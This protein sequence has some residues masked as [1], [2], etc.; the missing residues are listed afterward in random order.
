MLLR[1][2]AAVVDEAAWKYALSG[3]RM[4]RGDVGIIKDACCGDVTGVV[5]LLRRHT[6][7]LAGAQLE[8]GLV[9]LLAI[10]VA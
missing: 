6:E 7:W 1:A 8:V 2:A 3:V 9:M 10:M 5:R 4:K